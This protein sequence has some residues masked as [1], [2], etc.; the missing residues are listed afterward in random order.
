MISILV[1]TML[2][3]TV[4]CLPQKIV[5]VK[6]QLRE[7]GEILISR[8]VGVLRTSAYEGRFNSVTFL[9]INHFAGGFLFGAINSCFLVTI[10]R[11]RR[12]LRR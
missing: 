2:A 3:V 8:C 11:C 10:N 1:T 9:T 12:R 6:T 7:S 4:H 5:T